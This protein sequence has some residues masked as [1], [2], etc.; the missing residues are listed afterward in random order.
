MTAQNE[1]AIRSV[2][3]QLIA[4]WNRHD[5]HGFAS[6]FAEDADFVDVFGNWFKERREIERVLAQRHEGVFKESRF[7]EKEIA[8]RRQTPDLAIVHIVVELSGALDRQGKQMPPSL[9]VMTV[10]MS[11]FDEA[12]RII[13]LQNTAVAVPER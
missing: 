12:W 8:I 9:G 11:R 1:E 7:T 2:A 10:V 4:F 13:A 6:L 5:M 3:T